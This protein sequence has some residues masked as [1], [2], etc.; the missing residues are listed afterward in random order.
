MSF[1]GG[2]KGALR[3][4]LKLWFSTWLSQKEETRRDA[5]LHGGAKLVETRGWNDAS[6]G[7]DEDEPR[8]TRVEKLEKRL[9]IV[10]QFLLLKIS[11]TLSK[12]CN[13]TAYKRK[14]KKK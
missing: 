3:E 4:F 5:E 8:M 6:M 13:A 7:E 1:L 9:H 10:R 12:I 14:K 2:L 11:A